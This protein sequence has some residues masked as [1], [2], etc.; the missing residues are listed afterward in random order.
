MQL[1]GPFSFPVFS[2]GKDRK[3]EVNGRCIEQEQLVGK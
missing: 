2:P 3:A 1:D